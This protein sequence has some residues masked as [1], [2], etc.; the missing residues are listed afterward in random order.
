MKEGSNNLYGTNGSTHK[1]FDH[2]GLFDLIKERKD[3]VLSYSDCEWVRETYK[4]F[5]IIDL[6]WAYGMNNGKNSSELLIKA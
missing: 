4:E 2:Q 1:G 6:S 5:E 3:W